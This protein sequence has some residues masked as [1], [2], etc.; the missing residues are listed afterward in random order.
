M[1]VP[2]VEDLA[3]ILIGLAVGGALAVFVVDFIR[4][5]GKDRDHDC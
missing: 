2:T 4:Q 1:T 5:T 3:A